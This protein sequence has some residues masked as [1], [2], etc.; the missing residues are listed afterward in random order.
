MRTLRSRLVLS[1]ALLVTFTVGLSLFGGFYVVRRQLLNGTDFLL[2]A[3]HKEIEAKLLPLGRSFTV[4]ELD[5]AIRPHTT[6]DAP[7]YFFQVHDPFG[8]VLFR[9]SNLGTK[10]LPDLSPSKAERLSVR[11]MELGLLRVGEYR[12]PEWHIQIAS[13]LNYLSDLT[14]RFWRITFV[15][16]PGVFFFSLGIGYLLC[17]FTLRPLRHI[18]GTARRISHT[19]LDERIP[20]PKNKDEVARL[21][22][23][24]N[25][26]FDRLQRSFEQIKQFTADFSHE[27]RTPLSIVALHTE[28]VLQKPGL[29][30]ESKG[31]LR[32]ALHETRRINEVIDQLLTLAKAEAQ[33]LPMAR[34]PHSTSQF[35]QEFVEDA[36]AL[37]ESRGLEFTLLANQEI[38]ASFDASQI[39]QVLFNL[40]SNAIKFTPRG[41]H[42]QLNSV[43]RGDTWEI[44]LDDD[45]PGV[46]SDQCEIIFERFHQLRTSGDHPEGS[47]LGLAVARSIIELHNG[48]IR[49]QS[50]V[51][52]RGTRMIITLPTKG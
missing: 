6:L 20:V 3:E 40:L 23:L 13:S 38:T 29:D 33:A 10:L 22:Q 16:I 41:G 42:I 12:T 19:N 47:G 31:H 8:R 43:S 14:H 18:E 9:S 37:C 7:F 49:C 44:T 11:V 46:P 27:L 48:T 32:D 45:G 39:R 35:I 36:L 1:Y 51:T 26:M 25:A 30:A 52:D 15:A 17:E 34:A 28:K 2:D 50:P 5:D 21:A 24:L 4:Q